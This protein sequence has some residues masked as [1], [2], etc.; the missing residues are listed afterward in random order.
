MVL[1]GCSSFTIRSGVPLPGSPAPGGPPPTSGQAGTVVITPQYVALAPGQKFQFSATASGGGPIVWLVN[2]SLGGNAASGVID[3]NGNFTAPGSVSQSENIN[4]TAALA[5]SPQQN[6]ATAVVSILHQ[7]QI[8]CPPFTGNT[9]VA[10]YSVY[11]PAPGKA[12]VEF[13][14]S[15][16]YGLNTWQVETPSPNGGQIQIYVAGMQ[17]NSTYHMRGQVVLDNGASFT[18]P[19]QTCSTGAPPI[20]AAVQITTPSGGTPQ[21]GIEMWNTLVPQNLTQAFATDL[22]GNVIWTYTFHGTSSDLLQGIQLLPN[23]HF[24]MVLSYL[25]SLSVNSSPGL[26]NEVREIDLAGNTIRSV[27]MDA[28]N[29]SLAASDLRDADG[30]PYKLGSFH[31]S[32]LALPNGHWILLA[33]YIKNYANLPGRPGTTSVIGD[34][35]VDVD[36][37][38]NPVWAWNTFD[39]LDINRQP[40]NFPDWTHSNDILYSSDDHNLLLSIRHQ[41]WVVKIE[42]LDGQGSGKI[43]W[44]LGEGGDFKLIGGADP[45]DWFY[46]QHGMGYFTSNTTGVFRLGL[47]DNG[48]DR[49]FPAGQV[50][51][52]PG[53]QPIASCYSTAPVLELNESSMTATFVIHYAPPPSYFS[54]FGGNADRLPNGDVEADFCA[55]Y[56]GAI[57]QELDPTATQ[58]VW[59]GVTPGADQFHAVRMP[60]LYPGVQW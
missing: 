41:N 47:M 28:L 56:S 19:D 46:A 37:N 53:P 36:Q 27:T 17:A 13:G 34:A 4:V 15:T 52:R 43:L 24:L 38:A 2:G 44:H 42:Y 29:Q 26:L 10:S 11:L 33:T 57:V 60:S 21:P 14:K 51:C 9:Q 25:S 50:T 31:H 1:Q 30:D 40:M 20:T 32:V 8:T 3:S 54:Y 7:A 35:L 59:Q 12:L 5:S 6:Y 48:N 58:V 39:H 22:N 18:E 45:Q 55:T 49:I 16:S 23:G